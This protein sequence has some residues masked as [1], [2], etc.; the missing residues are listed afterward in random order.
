MQCIFCF[1]FHIRKKH[2]ADWPTNRQTHPLIEMLRCSWCAITQKKCAP[3]SQRAFT[4]PCATL[5]TST[6]FRAETYSRRSIAAKE[7]TDRSDARGRF[8]FL[9]VEIERARV[10]RRIRWFLASEFHQRTHQGPWRRLGSKGRCFSIGSP[11]YFLDASSHLYKR[12]CPSI[13]PSVGRSLHRSIPH[14]L[15]TTLFHS[16]STP[17]HF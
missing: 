2:G 3:T 9:K 10:V 13:R 1:L 17:H 8:L 7:G 4:T 16:Q 5:F 6:I 14:Y 15:N 12:V 11:T